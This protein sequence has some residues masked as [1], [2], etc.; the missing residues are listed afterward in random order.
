M[1]TPSFWARNKEGVIQTDTQ[2]YHTIAM[3]KA[4]ALATGAPGVRGVHVLGA[5]HHGSL[6]GLRRT[7]ARTITLGMPEYER[8]EIHIAKATQRALDQMMSKGDAPKPSEIRESLIRHLEENQKR[9]QEINVELKKLWSDHIEARQSVPKVGPREDLSEADWTKLVNER[10]DELDRRSKPIEQRIGELEK[11]RTSIA[12]YSEGATGRQLEIIRKALGHKKTAKIDADYSQREVKAWMPAVDFVSSLLSSRQGINGQPV[13][14]YRGGAIRAHYKYGSHNVGAITGTANNYPGTVHAADADPLNVIVHEIGHA[15][16]D[17]DPVVH[18]IALEFLQRRTAGEKEVKLNEVSDKP[19]E[20]NEVCKP[21]KFPNPYVGKVYPN[22]LATEVVS[23]GL[24]Y[25]YKDPAGF[26]DAD[27][28]YFD[29]M[30][31]I[32]KR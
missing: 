12:S 21:D 2:L 8:R 7:A 13:G 27:P 5:Y 4:H 19:F 32:L 1:G 20:D 31:A 29:T 6:E 26:A 30:M 22:N 23:M 10:I 17:K 18:Q 15:V 3:A 25:L 16:E 28:D 14:F 9:R 11:E 24:E